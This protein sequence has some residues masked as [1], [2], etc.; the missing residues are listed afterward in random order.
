MVEVVKFAPVPKGSTLDAKVFLGGGDGESV[1]R[2]RLEFNGVS[3]RM[4]GRPD[5]LYGLLE[6]LMMIGRYFC[7]DVNCSS[8]ANSTILDGNG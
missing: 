5:E 6:I 1:G 7:D 3:A 2:I 8:R 4:L